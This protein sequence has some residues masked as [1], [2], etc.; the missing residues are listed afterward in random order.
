MW[1]ARV[2]RMAAAEWRERA[3]NL[4]PALVCLALFLHGCA[5]RPVW[6]TNSLTVPPNLIQPVCGKWHFDKAPSDAH[7]DGYSVSVGFGRYACC[8]N[9]P[10]THVGVDRLR[11]SLRSLR[12]R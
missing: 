1:C 9:R 3:T 7:W 4:S 6:A 12:Y 5:H 8:R 2:L 10:L 11:A